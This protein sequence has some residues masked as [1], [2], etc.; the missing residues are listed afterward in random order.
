[1][2]PF[3]HRYV[4][5]AEASPRGDIALSGGGLTPLATDA[6]AEFDGPGNL[7]SPET[8]LVGAVAGLIVTVMGTFASNAVIRSNGWLAM[9]IYVLFGLGYAYLLFMNRQSSSTSAD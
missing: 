9:V 6:P 8:L 4:V 5:S 2:H 7:W 3:P 1:M